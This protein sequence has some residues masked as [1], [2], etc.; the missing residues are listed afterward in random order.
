MEK[1]D[2]ENEERVLPIL[3]KQERISD[4]EVV[5]VS[6]SSYT[7]PAADPPFDQ[8][9]HTWACSDNK[10]ECFMK[11]CTFEGPFSKVIAHLRKGM[12][13]ST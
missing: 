2:S 1:V 4:D 3:A 7:E 13:F 12:C 11:E 6:A 9:L 5:F 8:D 10:F